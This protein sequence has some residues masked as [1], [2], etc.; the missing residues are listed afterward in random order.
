MERKPVDREWYIR[1]A[2]ALSL[3]P[4]LGPAKING[5]FQRF[6]PPADIFR[7]SW[8]ELGNVRGVGA[9]I[10]RAIQRF[11]R[12]KE[13]DAVLES[14]RKQGSTIII[15]DDP[16]YPELLKEIPDPPPL[17][18]V[19]GEIQALK[20]PALA[21][22]G[23]RNPSTAG[24]EATIKLTGD[25]VARSGVCV[26]SGLARGIDTLAHRTTLEQQGCTV[27]VL[28]SGVDRIYPRENI[29]LAY[30]IIN[31]GG[32]VI[33]EYPPGTRPE[34]HH[35]PIRN[36][37]VSGISQGVLVTETR[38]EGG[39][40]IT[41]ENALDQN[42]EVFIVPHDIRRDSGRGSNAF[43][44]RGWGK[45]V[46]DAAD[47][48]EELPFQHTNPHSKSPV[49]PQTDK[50]AQIG[51]TDPAIRDKARQDQWMKVLGEKGA[52]FYHALNEKEVH[53]DELAGQLHI[54]APDLLVSL[55]ELELS[56]LVT[57]KPGKKF[58]AR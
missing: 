17:I 9:S 32:A 16:G 5:L 56:G 10:A 50:I 23:T 54:P 36:R 42:R 31:Q 58:A 6:S 27:A 24:R 8:A 21:V 46:M 2:L 13:V 38:L 34:A 26:V 11:D 48:L 40:R 52:V 22:V 19:R 3:I 41:L 49:K 29:R 18:W 57:Q 30:E 14:T 28:G 15:P 51:E 25:L 7:K 33:S 1:T 37:I 55:L 44:Q 12:W 47:I 20:K 39:S 43:I 45:L 53:I 35:F 4:A